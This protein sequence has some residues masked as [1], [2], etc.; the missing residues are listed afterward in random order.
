MAASCARNDAAEGALEMEETVSVDSPWPERMRKKI[1]GEQKA[2]PPELGPT[3]D[4]H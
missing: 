3:R 1:S 4:I 2:P